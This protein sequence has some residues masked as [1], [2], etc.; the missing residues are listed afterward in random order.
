MKECKD[1]EFFNG[2]C[3]SDGT[4]LCDIEGGYEQCPYND[5][6]NTKKDGIKI[7]IDSGFMHDYIRHTMTNTI[8]SEA[9]KIARQEIKSLVTEEIKKK[10]LAEMDSQI[11][12][13]VSQCIEEFMNNEITIGG[14]WSDPER[15]L[16]RNQYLAETIEKELSKTFNGNALK[17]YAEREAKSAIDKYDK[18]LRDEINRGIKTYFDSATR[19]ILT[20]NVVTMLMC[21]DTY[22]KMS[23]GLKTF[24]P[25]KS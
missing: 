11:K 19:D 7:E 4:P 14:G 9:Y 17:S 23:D 22:R 20:E 21:N 18:S 3:Y 5:Y 16:T 6:V 10:V 25:E 24:L 8:E 12:N 13:V 1:C 15:K 2:Y